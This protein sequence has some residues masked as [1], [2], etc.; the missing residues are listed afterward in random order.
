MACGIAWPAGREPRRVSGP[1]TNVKVVNDFT[2]TATIPPHAP[3][4]VDVTVATPAGTSATGSADQY[5]YIPPAPAV[6][7]VSPGSGPVA[8]GSTVTIS[9][10]SFTGA[11]AVDFGGTP[12]TT[13]TVSNDGSITATVPAAAAAGTVDVKVVTPYG[14]SASS[15]ADQYT[16][17]VDGTKLTAAPLLFSLSP[18]QVTV[19]LD[20]SATLT[21]TVTGQPVPG[22]TITFSVGGKTVCT[23]TTNAHGTATC[24]APCSVLAVLL[25]GRYTAT[26]A[27]SPALGPSS[28]TAGLLN[29]G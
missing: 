13:F 15:G 1:A 21:D 4:A 7:G 8:G 29:I 24:N 20:L 6:T 23:G 26:F 19:T 27:G 9:G 16:Y 22:A 2:V 14:T 12:A 5:A 3:G 18:S 17:T 25:A 28:A 11:T 10:S